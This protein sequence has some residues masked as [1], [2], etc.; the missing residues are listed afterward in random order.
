MLLDEIVPEN[1][2]FA[3]MLSLLKVCARHTHAG[4]ISLRRVLYNVRIEPFMWEY[5]EHGGDAI[6][7]EGVL[8]D[9][10]HDEVDGMR[11]LEREIASDRGARFRLYQANR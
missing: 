11:P 1:V 3:N 8:E 4:H 10:M 7:R 2:R 5:P 6:T 9:Y